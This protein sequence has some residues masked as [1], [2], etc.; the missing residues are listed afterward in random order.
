MHRFKK[1]YNGILSSKTWREPKTVI[2]SHSN[3]YTINCLI[4]ADSICNV[5]EYDLIPTT[6]PRLFLDETNMQVWV[7]FDNYI[8]CQ[9]NINGK[10]KVVCGAKKLQD[11]NLN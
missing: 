4:F 7:L 5:Q 3:A 6:G 11:L 9:T 10:G 1:S 8:Y 2:S